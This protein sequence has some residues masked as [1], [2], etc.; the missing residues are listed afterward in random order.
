MAASQLDTDV[1]I[2]GAGMSGL[3]FA[4]Q[5]QQQ[6]PQRSFTILEKTD[7]LGGTWVVNT[8][9]GCG[10]DVLSH[11]YSYSFALKPDWS[12][13]YAQQPEIWAYFRDVARRY[14]VARH[15]RYRSKVVQARFDE[16]TGTWVTTIVDE[17]TGKTTDMRSRVV[18]AAVGALSIPKGCDI[19]GVDRFQGTL[20]HSAQW[21][22]SF[23]WTDKQ[24]VVIGK[25]LPRS[26][27][28]SWIVSTT[29]AIDI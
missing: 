27:N 12:Q 24:V 5:L 16:M 13:A 23:D 14:D 17:Q 29:D 18:V 4:V 22:H 6:Y 8:Y 21:N 25:T 1:L 26:R 15:I 3:C 10:C 20:F 7:N 11:F 28:A 9:P 19:R 2:I